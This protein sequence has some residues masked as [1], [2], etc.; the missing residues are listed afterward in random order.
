MI[1]NEIKRRCVEMK[2]NGVAP[3][4]IYE[5]FMEQ[6][7][8]EQNYEAFKRSLRKWNAK[9]EK[10]SVFHNKANLEYKYI[11]H[12][13]TVQMDANGN[14]ERV[15]AKQKAADFN[16]TDVILSAI[17]SLPKHEKIVPQYK[18]ESSGMLEI[19]L[20]DM[21]FGICF[22]DYYQETLNEIIALISSKRW[23]CVHFIVGQDL[24][25]NNDFKGHTANLTTIEAV[26]M[27]RAFHDATQFYFNAIETAIE[28]ADIV[29]V[30]YSQGNHDQMVG[31]CFFQLLKE[32]FSGQALFDDDRAPRKA[33]RWN[34]VF[35][36]F[37]HCDDG[38]TSPKDVRCQFTI[39]FPTEFAGA[40]VREIHLGHLHTE[41]KDGDES[42]I[43]VRRLS[44]KNKTDAWHRQ[45][46]YVGSHKRFM[47]F[48]YGHDRLKS[49]H[50]I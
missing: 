16:D 14:I 18:T 19:P 2:Q 39:E 4:V 17:R 13:T 5:Y 27:E 28:N 41:F 15:W 3:K 22:L 11:P 45:N 40:D 50:Y 6:N 21:H 34:K 36:G 30:H 43:V 33:I 46:G 31:W 32:H 48:E 29:N 38:R 37:G 20:F 44:T 26:D 12:A 42:G 47:L 24:F 10:D 23:E 8:S 49:I 35:I 7:C 1:P 25:H 9:K